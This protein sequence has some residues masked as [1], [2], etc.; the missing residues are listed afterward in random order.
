MAKFPCCL[1]RSVC[2]AEGFHPA[3]LQRSLGFAGKPR[4]D[5]GAYRPQL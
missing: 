2:R 1:Y 4:V 3:E 5:G